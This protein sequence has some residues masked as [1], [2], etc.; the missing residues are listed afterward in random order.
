MA[1]DDAGNVIASPSVEV[2]RESDNALV[3]L[4]SDRAGS[5]ALANPFTAGVDGLIAF[6]VI[7]GAYKVTVTKGVDVQTFRYVGIGTNSEYDYTAPSA[8]VTPSDTPPLGDG[9][10]APGT[11]TQYAR[12]DHRHPTDTSLAPLN[13]PAFTGT[14]TSATAPP[15]D[16][17]TTKIPTT[18]WVQTE[19]G[20][21]PAPP[22]AATVAPLMDGAAAVG[23][24]TKYARE[25]H[26]HP[27]DTTRQAADADLTA[28]AGLTGTG[29]A[30]RTATDTWALGGA[31]TNA[32]LA[33]MAAFTF[34]GNNSG[35]AAVP[36]D[37]GIAALTTK[38]SPGGGDYLLISDQAASGAWKKIA[39]STLPGSAGGIP[40]A[41]NDGLQYGRQ[42]L[43][44]TQIAGGGGATPSD[45]L[46]IIDG[47]AAAGTSLL[48]S[49]G[50]HVHP[51][52]AELAAIAGLTSAADRL[53]Y[54]TGLGTAALATFTT[55]GRSLVDDADAAAA[56]TTLGLTAA[57]TATPAALSKTDD[58]NVTLTLGGTPLTALLQA[59]SITVGWSGTLSAA[60]GGFGA[61]VSAAAGVPIFTAGVATFTPTTGTGNIARDSSVPLPAT[62]APLGDGTAAVGVATK[63]AREDHVHPTNASALSRVNDTNVTLTL[64]GTPATA[65]LQAT[66]I[67]VGWSG[68]LAAGRGGFGMDVSASAGVPNF[69]AGVPTFL[70]IATAAEYLANTASKI[71]TTDK[72]WSAAQWQQI[73][74]SGVN[75]TPDGNLGIDFYTTLNAANMVM[76]N[77]VN[78]KAGQKG[79]I[80]LIQDGTGSRN[81]QTWEANYKFPGG[82]K[83]TLSTPAGS[84]DAISYFWSGTTMY[85]VA[86]LAFA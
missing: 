43:G 56:R 60:R 5:S 85:C 8:G 4:F 10:A 21:L 62:V 49:R 73:T 45:A 30:R 74:P 59:T 65:L 53:P 72:V 61:N 55:F 25:D 19:L 6:H 58:T 15:V 48:Y 71:L 28:L 29:I 84:Y 37:V 7:G 20:Q 79:V 34:K 42:S 81:I 38:A 77:P 27:S 76:K 3:S 11:A 24:T 63:Y 23:T 44:W 78:M 26:V 14:P 83:P 40:E 35:G 41:P 17:A 47:T 86:Q 39:I 36:G 66:S 13:S 18:A 33:Q 32:E 51:L 54:F 50:D 57:A 69:A 16:D 75:I 82:T 9:T 64:G 12:G 22:A 1:Q 2:R 80:F 31:V 67:T 70:G 52:D 68:T 46:P